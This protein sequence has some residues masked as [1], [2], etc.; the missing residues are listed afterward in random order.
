[1]CPIVRG[2]CPL[3]VMR[4]HGYGPA[5]LAPPRQGRR[6]PWGKGQLLPLPFLAG[7]KGAKVLFSKGSFFQKYNIT[8]SKTLNRNRLCE[9]LVRGH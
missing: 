4:L 1:M 7:E 9:R 6:N 5:K 3:A 2:R 8:K